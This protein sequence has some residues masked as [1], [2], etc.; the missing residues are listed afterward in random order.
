MKA[1][2]PRASASGSHDEL[3]MLIQLDVIAPIK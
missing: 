3:G 1:A 2:Y